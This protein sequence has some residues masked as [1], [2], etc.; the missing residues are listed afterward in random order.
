MPDGG[1]D[2]QTFQPPK[3]LSLLVATAANERSPALSEDGRWLAYVSDES[4]RDEV[5]V[6]GVGHRESGVGSRE[7]AEKR[8]ISMFGGV[9]PRWTRDGLLY[10]DGAAVIL[11]P[12]GGR[13]ESSRETGGPLLEA[14]LLF[15]R[16]FQLDAG[17]NL[18][19]YDVS[20]D[21]QRLL[22]LKSASHP[23]EVKIVSDWGTELARK[24]P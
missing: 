20:R 5:Y 14:R 24:V 13:P 1:R 4:G 23:R 16:R 2:I 17:G 11:A 8:K 19:D 9:E 6:Q 18:P 7:N 10:R 21:G 15:E 12:F 22:M 3:M